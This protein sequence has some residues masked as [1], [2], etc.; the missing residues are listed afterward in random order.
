MVSILDNIIKAK[1]AE[2]AAKK[3]ELSIGALTGRADYSVEARD[4]H[5][6]LAK[7]GLSVIA[8]VKKASPSRGVISRDLDPGILSVDYE[9]A[10][11]DAISVLT[12]RTYFSGGLDDLLAVKAVTEVPILRK[13]FVIDEYQIYE[14]KAF[15]A[16]AV[17]LISSLYHEAILS[18]FLG[19]CREI[20]IAAL[21]ETH[22]EKDIGK[23][24]SAR[25]DIIGINNR[26]LNTFE[27]DVTVTEQLMPLIPQGIL[28]VSESG[29]KHREQA[30]RAKMAGVDAV[31]VGEALV[32]AD[33]IEH[34][35][36]ELKMAGFD[37]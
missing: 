24:I 22:T 31:L 33:D 17:L 6:A 14:A 9:A 36:S 37:G 8:E 21:V 12:D 25:A 5:K 30:A 32:V 3:K 20:G 2:I 35:I 23:A 4:F 13:D 7:G 18:E 19:L 16:D 28:T 29:I 1:K 26:D 15:G 11:A 10:G 27:I 34:K